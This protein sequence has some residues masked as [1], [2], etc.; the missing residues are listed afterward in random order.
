MKNQKKYL[1]KQL[2]SVKYKSKKTD[3][4]GKIKHEKSRTCKPWYS[5]RE[6]ERE[7][8]TLVKRNIILENIKFQK[9]VMKA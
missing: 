1:Q 2:F 9:I 3:E 6:R 8:Y 7:S 5:K 4:E